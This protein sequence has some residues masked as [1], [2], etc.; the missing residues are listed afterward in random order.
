MPLI[1][2]LGR[3]SVAGSGATEWAADMAAVSAKPPPSPMAVAR[4]RRAESPRRWRTRGPRLCSRRFAHEVCHVST[5]RAVPHGRRTPRPPRGARRADSPRCRAAGGRRRFPV[6]QAAHRRRSRGGQPLVHPSDGRL[7]RPRRRAAHRHPPAPVAALRR[8]R[9]EAHLGGRGGGR[10]ARGAGESQPALRSACGREGFAALLHAVRGAHRE[11]HGRDDDLVVAL[12]LT[13]SG[14]FSKP[15]AAGRRPRIACHHPLLDA[16]HGV[17][18]DDA[19]CVVSDGD[20]EHLIEAF[21]AAARDADA[22]GFDMVDVKACHGYLVHEFLSAR[23]RPGP[24]GGGFEGRTRLL[25]TL[26]ERVRERVSA[27]PR[28]RA[29]LAL[30]HRALAHGRRTRRTVSVRRL[31][32][33]R[34]RLRRRCRRPAADRPRRADRAPADAPRSR[35]GR[36]QPLGR[37]PLH[38]APHLAARR[39]SARPTAI[40]RRRIRS[41]ACWRQIDAARRAKAA[42]PGLVMVGSGYTYLQ[43]YRR[44]CRAGRRCEQG[45][46][47]A[48]GLGRMVLSYPELPADSLAGRTA[49]P[50]RRSAARSPTARRRRG[51][52]SAAAAIRSTPTTRPCPRP[53]QMKAIKSGMNA[54]DT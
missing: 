40:R 51:T 28:R 42:V 32:A 43:D 7:G 15:T 53:P 31:P 17:A 29:A 23:R 10:A 54:A 47:D 22:A 44:A 46:I 52:A 5:R 50:R 6:G 18:P 48:V 11:R 39:L 3:T 4:G 12:Q 36:G 16:R 1:V 27:A 37:Q 19:A 49:R 35:R 45:W 2:R 38:R 9:R 26:V 13:H 30:R 20:V 41:W 21:L 24:W 34:L 8:E 25:R 33:L 14:R